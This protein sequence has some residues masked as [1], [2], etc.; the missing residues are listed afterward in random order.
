M[1]EESC[2]AAGCCF[3]PT[4]SPKCFHSNP[5]RYTYGAQEVAR[6]GH[7]ITVDLKPEMRDT[8]PFG[9]PLSQ[10]VECT[11]RAVNRHHLIIQIKEK[12][13]QDSYRL[14]SPDEET[15]LSE[16]DFEVPVS[17]SALSGPP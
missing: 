5:T 15:A 14:M 1:T 3:N 11:V 9:R 4:T 12:T 6:E 10:E 16:T 17:R 2:Q 13:S 8:D 7:L